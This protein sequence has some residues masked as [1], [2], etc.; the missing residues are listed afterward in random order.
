MR[1]GK[2]VEQFFDFQIKNNPDT[3]LLSSNIVVK[4]EKNTI[5]E[6]DAL[7]KESGTIFHVELVY[8]FY[9]FDSKINTA[10]ALDNWIGPNRNDRLNYK[11]NKLKEKQL[12]L[13]YSRFT[14]PILDNLKLNVEEIQQKVCFKAQLFLPYE[15]K[16]LPF[17]GLRKESIC[18]FYLSFD[19]LDVL[20]HYRFY[21]P[22]K[23][24]WLVEPHIDVDWLLFSEAKPIISR[25]ITEKRSP[26][27]WIV[28][29]ENN[30]Q[31][32][33]ITFW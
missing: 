26:M 14:K 33:F 6:L 32:C 25:F 12:P 19:R 28:D 9:L 18:G 16:D 1:L 21:I 10:N 15:Y 4:N 30:L 8:K 22:K 3:H 13:L 20:K 27:V 24:D 2:R 5:G 11:F 23:L 7:I 17:S 29:S 31:K